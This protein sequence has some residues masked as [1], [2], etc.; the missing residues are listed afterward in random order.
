MNSANPSASIKKK[1]SYKGIE[2]LMEA[3]HHL[4]VNEEERLK[5][6]VNQGQFLVFLHWLDSTITFPIFIDNQLQWGTSASQWII[7]DHELLERIG[8]LIDDAY[9]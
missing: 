8:F 6:N 1:F 9:A 7:D 2:Y 3:K 5:Y 4:Q